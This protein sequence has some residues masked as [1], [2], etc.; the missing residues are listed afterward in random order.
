MKLASYYCSH[1]DRR[2]SFDLVPGDITLVRGIIPFKKNEEAHVQPEAMPTF[3]EKDMVKT[4]DSYLR[5]YLGDDKS[6]LSDVTQPG[7]EF[8]PAAD[9]PPANYETLKDEMIARAPHLDAQDIASPV[10]TADN[11][12]V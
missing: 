9:D 10:F 12:R 11:R 6:P 8:S 7:V 2:F 3:N 1:Y 5:S 4:I